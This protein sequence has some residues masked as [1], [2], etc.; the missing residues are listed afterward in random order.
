MI[1]RRFITLFLVVPSPTVVIRQSRYGS[2]YAGTDISFTCTATLTESLRYLGLSVNISWSGPQSH[3]HSISSTMEGSNGVYTKRIS[4]N[5]LA[6][7]DSGTYTC[8]ATVSG[9]NVYSITSRQSRVVSV[10]GELF[11]L[12]LYICVS[13]SIPSGLPPPTVVIPEV[14][15]RTAGE[16]LQLTCTVTVV[17]NL[18]TSP[19]IRW[20][21]GSLED[22]AE[23]GTPVYDTTSTKTV[24]FRP[25]L[26]SHGARYTCEAVIDIP[27]IGLDTTTTSSTSVTVLSK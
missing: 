22:G 11:C 15:E 25:L 10:T 23:C 17:E 1:F 7:S 16:E 9:T 8:A 19:C 26:T 12:L 27:S 6:T 18:V 3:T 21:G 13:L 14:G 2:L 20:T 24:T 5:P 4:I